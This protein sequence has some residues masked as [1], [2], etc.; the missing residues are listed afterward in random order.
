MSIPRG[1]ITPIRFGGDKK[2]RCGSLPVEAVAV[3]SRQH[4]LQPLGNIYELL[5]WEEELELVILNGGGMPASASRQGL[6]NS[7]SCLP[8]H[9]LPANGDE[10]TRKLDSYQSR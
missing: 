9:P 4:I 2:L 8:S 1:A 5:D 6:S 7:K 10:R 3:S